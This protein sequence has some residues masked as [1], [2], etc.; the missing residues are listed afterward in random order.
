MSNDPDLR[1]AFVEAYPLYVASVL[2][3]RGIVVDELIAD[4]VVEGASVL[5]GLLATLESTPTMD[6]RHSPLELFREALRPIDRALATNGVPIPT[7]VKPRTLHPWDAYALSPGS[8]Q[9][10]GERAHEAHLRWG[11]A[12]AHAL[13]AFDEQARP[14]R[15]GVAVLCDPDD[16]EAIGRNL[17]SI[18]YRWVDSLE[19]EPLVAL[20]DSSIEGAREAMSAARRSGC[21]VV[22]YGPV[23]DIEAVGLTAAGV[24]KTVT[25][26]A[27]VDDLETV[28]PM[29]G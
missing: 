9:M 20:I 18:G 7:D 26:Q 3:A 14:L 5:D 4:A 15:P 17:D 27:V 13:G 16:A 19:D 6:Q 21:R 22:A 10:L 29:I 28:L 24:W 23:T 25:K 2:H 11:V 8:S 12:K 1:E